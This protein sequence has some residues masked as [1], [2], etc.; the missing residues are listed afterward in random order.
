MHES[1]IFAAE[2]SGNAPSIDLH[3]FDSQAAVHE[4]DL[5]LHAAFNRG[6]E[7]V[8]IIHGR[9]TGKLR[10]VIRTFLSTANIVECFRD[11]NNPGVTYAIIKKRG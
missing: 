8:E 10:E 9:G 7:V 2:L 1:T 6:D 5:F 11:G 3:G 4:L